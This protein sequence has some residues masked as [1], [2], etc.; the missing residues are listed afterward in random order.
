MIAKRSNQHLK[1]SFSYLE[2]M[3][4][5]HQILT[6]IIF[7]GLWGFEF[8]QMKDHALFQWEVKTK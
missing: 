7:W 8:L 6:E 4:Q 5:C 3:G 2:L 1:I